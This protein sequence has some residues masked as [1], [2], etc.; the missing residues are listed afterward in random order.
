MIET[1]LLAEQDIEE[2]TS[3]GEAI[4]VVERNFAEDAE[5]RIINPSKLRMD[6]GEDGDWP[7]ENAVV[8][9]MPGYVDWVETA[10]VKLINGFWDNV[11][12][13]LPTMSSLI[14]LVDM[15][16]GTFQ[17]VMEGAHI[18]GLRTGAQ[19]A[20][21]AKHLATQDATTASVY[22]AGTQG[23]NTAFALD[24]A[25]DIDTMRIFDPREDALERYVEEVGPKVD[26]DVQPI[27]DPEEGGDADVI[28]TVTTANEPFLKREWIED[29]A[30]IAALGTNQEVDDDIVRDADKIVVDHIEQSLHAGNLK[31]AVERGEL[32]EED[33]YGTIGE[34]IAGQKHGREADDE[35]FLYVPF[36]LA[37]HDIAI[38]KRVYEKATADG[39][40]SSF[41]FV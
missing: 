3:M 18:T 16:R 12:R 41:E 6:L 38:G 27:H 11:K 40:G 2:Y 7:N 4:D 36:G 17:V 33:L 32:S 31:P 35:I 23:R 24:E 39:R 19:A 14:V 10:G 22:G 13:D 28:V 5:G 37:A 34:I 15:S 20:V 30:V 9:S 29:G 21:G 26:M 8:V 25:L 1:S